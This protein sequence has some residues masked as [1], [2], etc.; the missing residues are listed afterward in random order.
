M[1]PSDDAEARGVWGQ[2]VYGSAET[3]VWKHAMGPDRWQI[4]AVIE[5]LKAKAKKEGLWNLWMAPYLDPKSEHSPG[6]TVQEY[7]PLAEIMGAVPWASEI[8]NCSAP[9]TGNMEV[10]IKY[11]SDDQKERFLKPLVDGSIR[12]CFAMTEKKVASSDATNIQSSIVRQGD[13]YVIDGLKWWTSGAMDPRCGQWSPA[14]VCSWA[15]V[16]ASVR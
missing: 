16:G 11:G 12:S 2:H 8:F 6:L 10:L 7:A 5:E 4:P 14:R 13:E 9:D 1:Q 3:A 15:L